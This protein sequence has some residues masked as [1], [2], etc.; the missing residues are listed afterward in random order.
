M[1]E[2]QR[3]PAHGK[4]AGCINDELVNVRMPNTTHLGIN[5]VPTPFFKYNAEGQNVY[6]EYVIFDKSKIR[7][8]YLLRVTYDSTSHHP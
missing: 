2:G 6:N 3:Q 8:C 5:G 1:I 7:L 4:R